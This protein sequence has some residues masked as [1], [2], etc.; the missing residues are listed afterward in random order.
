M[1]MILKIIMSVMQIMMKMGM[2]M[3]MT[4]MKMRMVKIFLSGNWGPDEFCPF[5]AYATGFE[6]KVQHMSS[7]YAS[8]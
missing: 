6:L 1:M 7:L 4:I 5:G 3:M 8:L 2:I